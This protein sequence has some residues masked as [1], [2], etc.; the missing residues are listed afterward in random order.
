MI[1]RGHP[2][3]RCIPTGELTKALQSLYHQSSCLPCL[4]QWSRVDGGSNPPSD[5]LSRLLGRCG[6]YLIP[7]TILQNCFR[8]WLVPTGT[9]YGCLWES[10]SRNVKDGPLIFTLIPHVYVAFYHHL[11]LGPFHSNFIFPSISGT[12]LRDD[13]ELGNSREVVDIWK[14]RFWSSP[15]S[16]S[17]SRTTVPIP[18]E[19][20]IPQMPLT[21]VL[22]LF[23]SG[24][25]CG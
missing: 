23:S 7:W 13:E 14:M 17:R 18:L 8:T 22:S 19:L 9:D 5:L 3:H 2:S 21:S 16:S 10:T 25:Y 11:E 6:Q 1:H 4:W 24:F 20:M 12:F 15:V